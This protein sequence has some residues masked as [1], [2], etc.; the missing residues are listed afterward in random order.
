[1]R[2]RAQKNGEK[3]L[4]AQL[5]R[6]KEWSDAAARVAAADAADASD[7]AER[8]AVLSSVMHGR[9]GTSAALRKVD[10]LFLARHW[11]RARR[12]APRLAC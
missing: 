4:R 9:G 1:M 11:V 10:L 2:P 8:L 7:H 3:K 6:T 12:A 5:S